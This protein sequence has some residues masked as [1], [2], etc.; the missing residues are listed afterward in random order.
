[1]SIAENIKKLKSELDPKGIKLVV[2]TKTQPNDKIMEAYNCGER[3]FGENLVQELHEKQEQLPKD[4][5]WQIIG[6]LQ[7]N[8]VKFIAP[9]ISLIQSIDSLKLLQEV[10]KQALKNK[11]VIDCLFQVYIADEETK[12]G[13]DFNELVDILRSPEFTAL[14]NVRITGLM[15]VATNT[16]HQ[17][18]LKDEFEELHVFFEGIKSSFFRDKDYFTEISMGMSNDFAVA[19]EA[20]STQVRV[21]SS[22]FG[23]RKKISHEN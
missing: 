8:K 18:Q 20:G 12:Y 2:V 13:L 11:R 21:G 22:I 19:V 16:E 4:I 14:E 7:S 3:L 1:M 6:H 15:G 23:K 17:K 10:N 5:S 9:Y